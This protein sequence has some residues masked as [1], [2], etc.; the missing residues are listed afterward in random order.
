MERDPTEMG[1]RDFVVGTS[2]TAATLERTATQVIFVR[3]NHEDHGW[4]DD[5]ERAAT[6]PTF[7]IDPAERIRCLR[8][9]LPWRFVA[10]DESE[11]TILGIGRIAA[12]KKIPPPHQIQPHEQRRL[13]HLH[14]AH[15]DLLLTHDSARDAVTLGYGMPEIADAIRTVKPRYH[16]FGHVG[17]P[18]IIPPPTSATR[19]FKVADLHWNSAG[20]LLVP[21]FA[22]LRWHDD[23]DHALMIVDAPWLVEYGRWTW[24]MS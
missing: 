12:T 3:G 17:D 9:G 13:Q 5:R 1:V 7:P 22:V 21:P 18:A 16:V 20:Q 4:L 24:E 23:D 8:T 6:T 10:P 11:I 14:G 2:Q 15:V 19:S